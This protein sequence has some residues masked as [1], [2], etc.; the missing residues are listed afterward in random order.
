MVEVQGQLLVVEDAEYF[1][2][3]P[4]KILLWDESKESWV[5]RYPALPYARVEYSLVS[6]NQ[7]LLIIA[8]NT[9]IQ[10]PSRKSIDVLDTSALIWYKYD[11]IPAKSLMLGSKVVAIGDSLVISHFC[12]VPQMQGTKSCFLV[13][14][15][16]LIS[17]AVNKK[18]VD[19][20]TAKPWKQL[21]D[22][23]HYN[24]TTASVGGTLLAM[25]G[26]TGRLVTK[27]NKRI[28]MYNPEVDK[29]LEISESPE[30]FSHYFYGT[31]PSGEILVTSKMNS[32][33]AYS[34]VLSCSL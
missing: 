6:C 30:T 17:H 4:N 24:M 14:L 13:N 3:H 31:M 20:K 25:G 7:Y 28:Y 10:N 32:Q 33:N 26:I 18:W 29:W 34:G 1:Q 9:V 16:E 11:S 22:L 5:W 12:A 21:C 27:S 23:P 19:K 2:T 15:P 8:G